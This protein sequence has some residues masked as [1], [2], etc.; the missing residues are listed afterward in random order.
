MESDKANIP[1][2]LKKD[3]EVIFDYVKTVLSASG[4]T[5]NQICVRWLSSEQLLDLLLI[6]EVDLFPNQLCSDQKLLFDCIN[7]VLADVCQNFPPWFSFVKPCLRS[8]YLVEVCEGV[9]WHLLP[10]PQP[11]TLDHL[12]TKDMNRTRTW[13]N[14]HSDAE[15]IGT[16]TCDAIFDDL[17]DDTILSCVCDSSDDL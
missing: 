8:D 17:V 13:I 3:K 11:L 14:I 2:S 7:E 4:L 6:E 12:V 1:K 15:S 9:Y 16:E 10:M 5:W